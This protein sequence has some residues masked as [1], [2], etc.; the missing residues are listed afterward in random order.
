M[1]I[2]CHLL[3]LG[4]FTSFCSRAFRHAVKLLVYALSS[5]FLKVLR[6]MSFLLSTAFIVS[7][8]F[9]YVVSSFVLNTKWSLI[10]L[11][12]PWPGYLLILLLS[13]TTLNLWWSDRIMGLIN[14]SYICWGL[15]CVWVCGQFWRRYHKVLRE[16]IFF[17][18]RVKCSIG[19][20]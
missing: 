10:S 4:V 1:I 14:C 13:K 19:I 11:F 17:C 3:L 6:T 15:F 8:K 20:C 2:S 18:F 5:F 9:G 12:L 7:H 16:G